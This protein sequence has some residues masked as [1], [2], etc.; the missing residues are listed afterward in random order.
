MGVVSSF[1]RNEGNSVIFREFLIRMDVIIFETHCVFYEI[2][3]ELT[4]EASLQ[5]RTEKLSA[6]AELTNSEFNKNFDN[7]PIFYSLGNFYVT[8]LLDKN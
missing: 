8:K 2:I 3:H 7:R 5:L 4:S 6:W 1:P